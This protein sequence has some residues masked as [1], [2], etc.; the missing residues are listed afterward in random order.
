MVLNKVIKCINH[1]II[2]LS[3][4]LSKTHKVKENNNIN[5]QYSGFYLILCFLD[6]NSLFRIILTGMENKKKGNRE[7][8]MKNNYRNTEKDNH[9]ESKGNNKKKIYT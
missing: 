9:K 6:S 5:R 3:H 8:A 4:L 2:Y 7:N 1:F